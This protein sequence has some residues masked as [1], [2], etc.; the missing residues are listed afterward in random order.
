VVLMS[1]YPGFDCSFTPSNAIAFT[2]TSV[3]PGGPYSGSYNTTLSFPLPL[4]TSSRGYFGGWVVASQ[5][6]QNG[7][8]AGPYSV[9]VT[10]T[11]ASTNGAPGMC[12]NFTVV[13]SS[14]IAE[15]S[16][17]LV[18]MCSALASFMSLL[19]VHRRRQQTS[20]M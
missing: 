5:Y 10:D 1:I 15:F 14:P 13:S 9:A 3:N 11:E 8:P 16:D 17:P 7:F 2:S 19:L 12:K 20:R 4:A 18:V 6:Y